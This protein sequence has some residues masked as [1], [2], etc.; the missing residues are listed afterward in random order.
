M[1]DRFF[2]SL[3]ALLRADTLLAR[4][5][6]KRAIT[7]IALLSIALIFCGLALIMLNVAAFAALAERWSPAWAACAVG[8][9]DLVLAG[10]LML[11]ASRPI[12]EA[13]LQL[14]HETR[15]AAIDAMQQS[16][17]RLIE[18]LLR[19]VMRK[20]KTDSA[21]GADNDTDAA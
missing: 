16:A 3:R 11:F 8:A 4:I 14:A 10:I 7:G 6:L 21:H 18:M 20:D 12:S 13:T 9:G 19:S 17:P 2:Q 1:I 15:E 5:R